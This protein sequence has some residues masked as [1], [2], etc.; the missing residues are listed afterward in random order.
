[1][2]SG[3]SMKSLSNEAAASN[4]ANAPR[5]V[6]GRLF[7]KY[8]ALFVGIV[9]VAL[10]A[11]SISE[12]WM[13]YREQETFL[14]RAQHDR[15]ETAADKISQFV[16]EIEGQIGWTTQLPWRPGDLEDRH[17]DAVRLLRQMSAI[18][19]LR[20]LDRSGHEQLRVSRRA[21]DM[22]GSNADFSHDIEFIEAVKKKIYYGPVYFL[23]DSEPHMT[24]AMAGERSDSLVSVARSEEHTSELQS[25]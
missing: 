9:C 23:Q 5:K 11:S 8:V 22:L 25:H 4:A 7:R 18:A 16:K 13:A 12:I 21:P 20:Q 2:L 15:A 10:A 17:I 1:M 24:I 19:E 6:S 3:L 14:I